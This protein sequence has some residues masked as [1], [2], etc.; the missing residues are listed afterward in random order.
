[1]QP[2][3]PA[4]PVIGYG[5]GTLADVLPSVL[6]AMGVPGE[7]NPLALDPMSRAVVLLVDGMGWTLLKRHP[8]VAPFLNGLNERAVTAGF[9]A[10]TA[11]SLA[12]LGT[13]RPPGQH[14]FTG[15]SSYL[16]EIDAPVNW[17]TWRAVSDGADLRDRL[18]PEAVQPGPT[19]FER[20]QAAGVAVTVAA[21]APFEG[22]GLSRAVLRGGRYAG[23]VTHGDVLATV[24]AAAT[25]GDRS[26]VYCYLSELDLIGHVRGP[27]SDAWL[28]QLRLVDAFVAR[29]AAR[30][31]GST[32]LLITADHGMVRV[33][34]D[35]K[36]DYDASSILQSGVRAIA[37]EPRA[38][39]LHVDEGEAESVLARW[40]D[41][42]GDRMWLLARDEAI[43]Q[44]L[45][46]PVVSS[47]ARERIGDVIAIS[48]T[49]AAV[50]RRRAESRLASLAGQH[51]ALT[52]DEL[53][54]PLLTA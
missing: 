46:G 35:D 13:G 28:E 23:T 48:H 12:S 34:E 39:Y 18:V 52:E 27:E 25:V 45:F 32:N 14:G 33:D 21:P 47:T 50:V 24:A 15:Y 31:T 17:L 30:L 22:S 10:T 42:L 2:S 19:A 1:M 38:R 4:L 36:I 8:E 40:R 49:R 3:S 16:A 53:W 41:T 29:L 9:P 43:A 6:S 11:T 7:S 20:A 26:L 37:G 54:V 51:G 44:G 5:T